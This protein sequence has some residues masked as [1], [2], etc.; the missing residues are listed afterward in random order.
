M[1]I[2]S[3]IEWPV[4]HSDLDAIEGFLETDVGFFISSVSLDSG[5]SSSQWLFVAR[6]ASE[7][8]LPGTRYREAIV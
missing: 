5:M 1:D 3:L 7:T 6:L 8:V 4:I 2:D